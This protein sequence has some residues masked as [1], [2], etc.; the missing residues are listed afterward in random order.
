MTLVT[1]V[2]E[3]KEFN[4][5]LG[6]WAGEG[7]GERTTYQLLMTL[8]REVTCARLTYLTIYERKI[9]FFLNSY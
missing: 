9:S 3:A 8:V 7:E 2:L 5:W 6:S 1:L 4:G